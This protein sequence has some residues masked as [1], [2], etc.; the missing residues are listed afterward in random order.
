[1]KL[2]LLFVGWCGLILLCW[3]ATL[4]GALLFRVVFSPVQWVVL[5]TRGRWLAKPGCVPNSCPRVD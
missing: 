3:V 1:M 5:S 4:A 2:L